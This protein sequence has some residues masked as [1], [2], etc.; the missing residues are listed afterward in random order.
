MGPWISGPWS[1]VP[2]LLLTC[3]FGLLTISVG[4]LLAEK[5]GKKYAPFVIVGLMG[6]LQIMVSFTS[7]KFVGLSVGG[8]EYFIV[9]G[10]LMY[11]ILA[12]GEDYLNEFYGPKIAKSS[13]YAQFIV[14]ALSTLFLI[15]LIFLPAPSFNSEN[16][17]TFKN[18]MGIVPRVAISSMLATY[19][20]GI[21]NVN[22]FDFVKRRT[23]GGMLWLRTFVS[24]A[25]GLFVNAI[26]F[27][28]L[29]F[30]FVVPASKLIE[31]ILISVIVR[32]IT[33]VLEIV[34]LYSMSYFRDKGYIL[35]S[36]EPIIVA[37]ISKS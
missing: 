18:L 37:P 5:F 1:G 16:F 34:F 13:V 7:S 17:G 3:I 2:N 19:V 15:W 33:G 22:L 35:Q 31:M 23:E 10:S 29:A 6:G 4:C 9:A 8:V 25:T 11:P 14:R 24:T 12:L 20:G 21:I 32:L 36:D 27:T 30:A 26:I 28:L